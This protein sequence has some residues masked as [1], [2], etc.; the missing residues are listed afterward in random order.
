MNRRNKYY[1]RL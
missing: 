1:C